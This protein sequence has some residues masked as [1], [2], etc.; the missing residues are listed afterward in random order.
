MKGR[1]VL[2]VWALACAGFLAGCGPAEEEPKPRGPEARALEFVRN[3]IEEAVANPPANETGTGSEVGDPPVDAVSGSGTTAPPSPF[4]AAAM[5]GEETGAP[6]P[7]APMGSEEPSAQALPFAAE[8][9]AVEETAAAMEFGED[10]TILAEGT[11]AAAGASARVL[12]AFGV[13][14]TTESASTSLTDPAGAGP[15]YAL[16]VRPPTLPE[17]G[18]EG[19]RGPENWARLAPVCAPCGEG[20]EQSPID[21][22]AAAEVDLPN[23]IFHYGIT[24]IR[25]ENTGHTLQLNPGPGHWIELDGERYDLIQFHFHMPSEHAI[26]GE[27]RE[28]EMHLVHRNGDGEL[29]VVAVFMTKGKKN[30]A[31]AEMLEYLPSEAGLS[32]DFDDQASIQALLPAVQTAYRYDGS[33]TTPPCTEGVKWVVLSEPITL[34]VAQITP[35]AEVLGENVRPLQPLN[36]R[37]VELDTT[38]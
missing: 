17:W 3:S 31:Y 19:E 28:G 14:V 21:L 36:E 16:E 32:L 38:P 20:L 24:P 22:A 13:S 27:R 33:L 1:N 30:E 23:T 8:S 34:S 5:E 6:S 26:G 4:D 7:F 18:Y 12:S 10:G 2:G 37:A 25:I 9:G 35:I 29:A 15:G 11:P